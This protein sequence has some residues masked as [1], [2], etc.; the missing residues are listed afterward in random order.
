MRQSAIAFAVLS[1]GLWPLSTRA[2]ALP[3]RYGPIDP[4]AVGGRGMRGVQPTLLS[5]AGKVDALRG[6]QTSSDGLRGPEL[7]DTS[8]GQ[9]VR[10]ANGGRI[11]SAPI[12]PQATIIQFEVVQLRES[13]VLEGLSEAAEARQF[14]QLGRR[15]ID[16]FR[17]RGRCDNQTLSTL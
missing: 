16:K 6:P 4:M 10:S 15:R 8:T 9:A 1:L 2:Q 17:A 5:W 7:L 14:V 11:Q 12:A 13:L 3:D